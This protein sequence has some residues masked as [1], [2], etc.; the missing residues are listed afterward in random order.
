MQ[1][2]DKEY[3]IEEYRLAV[4]EI[5]VAADREKRNQAVDYLCSLEKTIRQDYGFE[6]LNELRAANGLDPYKL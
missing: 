6:V 5:Q 4:L 1:I 2:H 3:Y